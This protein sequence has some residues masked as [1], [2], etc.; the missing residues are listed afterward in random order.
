MS[1]APRTVAPREIDTIIRQTADLRRLCLSLRE[2][3]SR[4][5]EARMDLPALR[6]GFKNLWKQARY[7]RIVAVGRILSKD[8]IEGDETALMYYTCALKRQAESAPWPEGS[9]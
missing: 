1:E 2:A 4:E 6:A 8:L 3:G 7:H 9:A 5:G